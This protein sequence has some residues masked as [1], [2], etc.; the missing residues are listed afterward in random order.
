MDDQVKHI[1]DA[2][3][4]RQ[5]IERLFLR[6]PVQLKEKDGF[7]PVKIASFENGI[8]TITHDREEAPIRL[9]HLNHNNNSMFL[10]CAVQERADSQEKLKPLKLH[11]RRQIRKEARIEVPD[12][13]KLTVSN[14]L[15]LRVFPEAFTVSDEKRDRLTAA[16]KAELKKKFDDANIVFRLTV[17]LDYKMRILNTFRKPIYVPDNVNPTAVDQSIFL[18]YNEYLKL[19][20]YDKL[21]EV[22]VAEIT[23]PLL[24]RNIFLLGYI[25]VVSSQHLT[26]EDYEIV[27]AIGAEF[28]KN[29]EVYGIIPKNREI[30]P[31]IDITHAGIGCMHPHVPS[32]IRNFMPGEH[33]IFNINFPDDPGRVFTGVIK[34][35]KSLEKAHRLGIQFENLYPEQTEVLDAA[36]SR[37]TGQ[38]AAIPP[39]HGADPG[40]EKAPHTDES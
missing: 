38:P 4:L 5:I 11:L 35:M 14:L 21:P 6:L 23:E 30:C 25:R 32:M 18:P 26:H 12:R 17:R 19:S 13:T 3:Q 37:I 29:M 40:P 39:A 16:Y 1:S 27:K 34:N 24:Y 10:E 8:I 9:I 31:V 28:M 7:H 33:V 20:Q 2:S 15:T 22:Y 36:L